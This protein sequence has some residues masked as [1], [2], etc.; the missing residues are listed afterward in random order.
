MEICLLGP[1]ALHGPAGE[2]DLGPP[3]RRCIF[4]ALALDPG[5]TVPT[6]ELIRRVW[7][8]DPPAHVRKGLHAHIARLRRA[9]SSDPANGAAADIAIVNRGGG[10]VL[11]VQ[12]ERTDLGRFR[13]LTAAGREA[14]RV[15]DDE[16]AA[17]CFQQAGRLWRGDPLGGVDST[18]MADFRLT[19]AD[20]RLTA[21]ETELEIGLRLG[22]HAD[23]VDG[24]Q[25][26]ARA[27]LGREY[28]VG[29]AMRYLYRCGRQA[30]SLELYR[31]VRASLTDAGL[32]P[33][34]ELRDLQALIL[35]NDP[36]LSAPRPPV[37]R[38]L[39][40][41]SA[42]RDLVREVRRLWLNPDDE[43]GPCDRV[44]LQVCEHPGAVRPGFAAQ[45]PPDLITPGP[46][47]PV[48]RLSDLLLD[49]FNRRL[50][51]LG[52]KGS[53]KT[54]TLLAL[55]ADLLAR[56]GTPDVPVPVILLLSRWR[57][58]DLVDWIVE[59]VRDHYHL[60]ADQVRRLL[61][62]GDIIVL[63]DGLDEVAAAIR[64][65]CAHAI[66]TLR[67]EC[68][69][70]IVVSSRIT[71]Y[72]EL[73]FRLAL[74]GAVTIEPLTPAQIDARLRA[75]GAAFADLRDV[76]RRDPELAE[77][78][79]TP[80]MLDVVC[81]GYLDGRA[82]T[83]SPTTGGSYDRYLVALLYRDRSTHATAPND[84]DVQTT[85]RFLVWLARLMTARGET[86]W[87]PDHL[88]PASLPGTGFRWSLPATV[89]SWLA[90]RI[91]LAR[92]AT[93]A[94][95]GL[96][97]ATLCGLMYGL[98]ITLGASGTTLDA[99][100]W[101]AAVAA[102]TVFVS[103]IV[104]FAGKPG[105]VHRGPRI[106]VYVLLLMVAGGLHKGLATGRERGAAEGWHA[107]LTGA[108]V[109]GLTTA[110]AVMLGLGTVAVLLCLDSARGQVRW[111]WSWRRVVL[112]ADTGAACGL[113]VGISH[114]LARLVAA[115]HDAGYALL[116]GFGYGVI[117]GL[118]GGLL[119]GLSFMLVDL[120]VA[121][122]AARWRLSVGR[123]VRAL[124]ATVCFGL[125][126]W[127]IFVF[128]VQLFLGPDRGP[129]FSLLIGVTFCL[130]F[131]LGHSLVPEHNLPV[132]AP[133]YALRTSL[134][135]TVWPVLAGGLV[136]L[137][138]TALAWAD[139]VESAQLALAVPT[140]L[141]TLLTFW[142]TG[143]GVWLAHQ[144]ARRVA[145]HAGILPPD[146]LHF[147]A[148]A[149]ERMLLDRQGGGYR[150]RHPELQRHVAEEEPGDQPGVTAPR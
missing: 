57:G 128:V 100:P 112:G 81:V 122:P 134:R 33:G 12:P 87:Y 89:V 29:L 123:L 108:V 31:L 17:R 85:H 61:A 141:T 78:L 146:L 93:A 16:T 133:A 103:V 125:V 105:R 150:F 80:H 120:D 115:P 109:Y 110:A 25:S 13:A 145:R 50:L 67:T 83:V 35:R 63:L 106:A 42:R 72:R 101:F 76:V 135:V 142:F 62:A 95:Y 77:H 49:R 60:R 114:A 138:A 30:E 98:Q 91:G 3:R 70:G 75:G 117:I 23:L 22:E 129:L 96:V 15:G 68:P 65:A 130:T 86:T 26:L 1:V 36:S 147:L 118:G 45:T 44:E 32:E 46:R 132:P 104:V 111:T 126:H 149:D 107:G 113:A 116:T 99:S 137:L 24:A 5:R 59:E 140:I 143:G 148:Y 131:A 74:G 37:A 64:P 19:L 69:T 79:S 27:N 52:D 43:R 28:L 11:L 4:V 6:E 73:G 82:G 14:A 20:Q 58:D 9:I 55:A 88:A 139:V 21:A 136:A 47:H 10:Y 127:L 48:T 39:E 94:T 53:G 97:A 121:R 84:Y 2:V 40:D 90:G 71:E 51:L 41:D 18:W 144:V 92:L 66:N 8:N 38:H 54:T 124:V 34:N 7:G 56:A 119:L 102:L